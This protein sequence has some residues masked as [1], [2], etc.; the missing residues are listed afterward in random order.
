MNAERKTG[1]STGSPAPTGEGARKSW[2][3]KTPIEVVLEQIHKQEKKV[4]E[5]ESQLGT[6][7]AMLSKLLQ[8][9]RVLE[10]T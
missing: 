9:K 6:E 4:G 8:A 10:S 3:P 7:K 1:Q 5:L 2:I